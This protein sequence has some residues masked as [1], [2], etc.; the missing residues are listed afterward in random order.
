MAQ[1]FDLTAMSC[2]DFSSIPAVSASRGC[3]MQTYGLVES[4][5]LIR[6]TVGGSRGKAPLVAAHRPLGHAE[7]ARDLPVRDSLVAKYLYRH[8]FL[9]CEAGHPSSFSGSQADRI[10]RMAPR[11]YA[12][13]GA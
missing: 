4:L 2:L 11:S 8:D 9:S 10:G 7:L 1:L 12:G 5:A 6:S 3:D 13:E